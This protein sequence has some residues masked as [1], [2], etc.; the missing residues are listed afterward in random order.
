[1]LHPRSV[2]LWALLVS[3]LP[4]ASAASTPQKPHRGLIPGRLAPLFADDNTLE[5]SDSTAAYNLRADRAFPGWMLPAVPR[6][7]A[8]ATGRNVSLTPELSGNQPATWL[9]YGV[10][11]AGTECVGRMEVRIGVDDLFELPMVRSGELFPGLFLSLN[12]GP[13]SVPGGRHTVVVRADPE[14]RIRE[15]TESDNVWMG[16]FVWSP[17]P[18][19][20]ETPVAR[21]MPPEPGPFTEPNCDGFR[22]MVPPAEAWVVAVAPRGPIDDYDLYLYDDYS[23]PLSGFENR[24]AA[25]FSSQ[26]RI[27]FVVG[28]RNGTPSTV[29]P[30]VTRFAAGGRSDFVI[31]ATGS[32]GRTTTDL[33]ASWPLQELPAHRLADVYEGFFFEGVHYRLHL[34]RNSGDDDLSF[35]VYPS[36]EGGLYGRNDQGQVALGDVFSDVLEFDVTQTGW[37]PV[38][39]YRTGGTDAD[40]P[41]VYSFYWTSGV[42][43][44]PVERPDQTGLRAW[45]N[46]MRVEATIEF[47]MDREALVTLDVV[48][49][50]GRLIRRLCDQSLPAGSHRQQWN[51]RDDRGRLSPPGLYWLR[52]AAGSGTSVLKLIR[53]R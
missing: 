37:H 4:G 9:N 32:S 51:G 18:L 14:D 16:Q 29:Y 48:D 36:A 35:S 30:G 6:A 10:E 43:G 3:V 53:I 31:D 24:R 47:E 17:L 27:D 41:L 21:P 23:G 34:V 12:A 50:Q 2:I 25:S 8:G 42:A 38:V 13:F 46:P 52:L 20:R 22:F 7:S 40:E 26:N 1:L 49:V 45:P 39:V 19:N 11:L 28:H 33:E 15:A 5:D 44:S